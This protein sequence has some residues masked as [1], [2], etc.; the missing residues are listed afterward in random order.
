MREAPFVT[1]SQRAE[2]RYQAEDDGHNDFTQ[3][4]MLGYFAFV[5]APKLVKFR[6]V[7][8]GQIK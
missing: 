6:K 3:H 4:P 1:Q 8:T 2:I 7:F 5:V